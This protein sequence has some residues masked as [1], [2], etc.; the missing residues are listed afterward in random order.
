MTPKEAYGF[1]TAAEYTAYEKGR[2]DEQEVIV[3][4]ITEWDGSTN[5][6]MGQILWDK[7]YE[8]KDILL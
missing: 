6:S 1:D 5:S 8:L 2:D 4:W 7:F 3:K